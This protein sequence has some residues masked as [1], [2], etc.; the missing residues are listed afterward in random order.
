MAIR[1]TEESV[2]M[3]EIPERGILG[4]GEHGKFLVGEKLSHRK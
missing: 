1:N 2:K 3:V 4:K